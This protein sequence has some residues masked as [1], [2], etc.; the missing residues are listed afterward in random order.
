MPATTDTDPPAPDPVTHDDAHGD[1]SAPVKRSENSTGSG[2]AVVTDSTALWELT[3][4]AAS[5]ALTAYEYVVP[6]D[7]PVSVVLVE[8]IASGSST[9]LRTNR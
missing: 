5:N 7:R 1:P 2:A 8:A 9:P 4:P 3:F 6:G